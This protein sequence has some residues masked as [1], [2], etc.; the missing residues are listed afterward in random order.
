[1]ITLKQTLINCSNF[2]MI[3]RSAACCLERIF[4]R[5]LFSTLRQSGCQP[6]SL[7]TNPNLLSLLPS[8]D[9]SCCASILAIP[10][11]AVPLFWQVPTATLHFARFS[12]W[13]CFLATSNFQGLAKSLGSNIP[14]IS[15]LASGHQVC[16]IHC[17]FCA[18]M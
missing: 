6:I 3:K 11:L 17:C 4:S 9:L 12:L 2:T 14:G 16:G 8:G 1:M 13:F 7:R 18:V 5:I 10:F 15:S